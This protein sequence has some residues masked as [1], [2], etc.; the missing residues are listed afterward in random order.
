[1]LRL[2]VCFWGNR[3]H[4]LE[5]YFRD[6]VALLCWN[7]DW[8]DVLVWWQFWYQHAEFFLRKR[9]HVQEVEQLFELVLWCDEFAEQVHLWTWVL[10]LLYRCE[11]IKPV[12][13][14]HGL[15]LVFWLQQID[16]WLMQCLRFFLSESVRIYLFDVPQGLLDVHS[17]GSDLLRISRV[18]SFS[19]VL[20]FW[21]EIDLELR[22]TGG[23]HWFCFLLFRLWCCWL[24]RWGRPIWCWG[25]LRPCWWDS[26][27]LGLN[28]VP[29]G[30][31]AITIPSLV[32]WEF[33]QWLLLIVLF[34]SVLYSCQ[35]NDLIL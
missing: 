29:S 19:E 7:F 24:S 35:I 4:V 31:Q 1:M 27:G 13:V 18:E 8:T 26:W 15:L 20:E 6:L 28:S 30:E 33:F 25:L 2:M 16:N 17:L 10:V 21:F 5:V 23:V 9:S 14:N 22:S 11:K 3:K 12:L 34:Q 32:P